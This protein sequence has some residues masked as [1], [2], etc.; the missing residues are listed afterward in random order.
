[1]SNKGMQPLRDEGPQ[2]SAGCEGENAPAPTIRDALEVMVE[3]SRAR[4]ERINEVLDWL[5]R[6]RAAL[7][8][9]ADRLDA[10]LGRSQ[11]AAPPAI[12]PAPIPAPSPSQLETPVVI[13]R[14]DLPSGL[15]DPDAELM[16]DWLGAEVERMRGEGWSWEALAEIGFGTE[17]LGDLGL[18]ALQKPDGGAPVSAMA[19]DTS[20]DSRSSDA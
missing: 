7:R 14:P 19:A 16:R 9:R 5:D 12:P 4:A 1:M 3:Q 18:Q 20:F 6:R 17:L 15:P 10:L 13:K 8:D 2:A 11:P